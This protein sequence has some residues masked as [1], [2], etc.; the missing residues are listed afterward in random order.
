[1]KTIILAAGYSTR[2]YPLTI[3]FPKALLP[4]QG[5][6]IIKYML[7]DLQ[8]VSENTDTV[9]ITNNRYYPLFKT[10][11]DAHFPNIEVI[12]NGT[13]NKDNRLGAI[14][15]LQFVLNQKQWM[16]DILVLPSDTLYEF[17]LQDVVKFF[18][19]GR[20]FTSVVRDCGDL[21]LIREKLGCAEVKEGKLISFE[22]KPKD[23]KSTFLSIPVY[24]Y[25]EK[26]VPLIKEYLATGN[27]AD[28][29]GAIIPWLLQKT[30]CYAFDMDGG[31]SYDVGTIEMFN[32]LNSKGLK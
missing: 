22:E 2:L 7:E 3:N 16:D 14:G 20:G 1:M 26:T 6:E 28:S 4:I 24:I 29:P 21:E 17:K 9:L 23:P 5:K 13:T 30:E 18:H 11:I 15:D 25:P 32:E 10:W 12:D 31:Y 19:E 8:T 27:N